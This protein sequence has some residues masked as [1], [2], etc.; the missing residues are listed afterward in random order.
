MPLKKKS[1]KCLRGRRKSDN[2]C[3]RKPGPKR[4]RKKYKTPRRSRKVVKSRKCPRGR[5]K[6]DNKCKRK[7]GPKR[8]RRTR[9]RMTDKEKEAWIKSC[10]LENNLLKT[11]YDFKGI[12]DVRDYLI[13]RIDVIDNFDILKDIN[14][15]ICENIIKFHLE[16]ASHMTEKESD[17]YLKD[18]QNHL[19]KL[20]DEQVNNLRQIEREIGNTNTEID[21]DNIPIPLAERLSTNL[22]IALEGR[23]PEGIPQKAAN[24][25]SFKMDSG[26]IEKGIDAVQDSLDTASKKVDEAKESLGFFKQMKDSFLKLVKFKM[27]SG[28]ITDDLGIYANR[29]HNFNKEV[30]GISQNNYKKLNEIRA[31][32]KAERL[33]WMDDLQNRVEAKY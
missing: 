28:E 13:S 2:K 26:D 8:S 19:D 32:T 4:S 9:F 3:R 30:E 6:S 21:L 15:C 18:V 1:R 10:I 12:N 29:V 20:Y 24:R 16:K 14:N 22:D 27:D 23:D 11:L 7:P 17:E 31:I 5:R 25:F 33:K